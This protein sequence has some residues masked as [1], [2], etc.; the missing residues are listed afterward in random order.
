MIRRNSFR[1]GLAIAAAGLAA[2]CVDEHPTEPTNDLHGPATYVT[3]SRPAARGLDRA[4]SRIT[5]EVPGF[6]GM[7]YDASGRLNVRVTP[8]ALDEAGGHERVMATLNRHLP[9]RAA[10]AGNV[11]FQQATESFSRLNGFH[12]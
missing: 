6:G 7:Y 9:Q 8:D 1:N 4:F 3:A 12:Q 10:S 5:A 2:G 11:V